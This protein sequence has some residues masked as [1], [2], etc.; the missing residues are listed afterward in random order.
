MAFYSGRYDTYFILG[1]PN[2]EPLWNWNI[3]SRVVPLLDPIISAARGRAAV[4]STQYLPD[5]RGTVKFGRIGWNARGHQKWA[6]GSPSN[7]EESSTWRFLDVEMWAPSWS[8]C[9]DRAPDVFLHIGNEALGGGYNRELA[10]NP[11]IILAVVAHLSTEMPVK[12]RLAVNELLRITDARLCGYKQRQWGTPTGMGA[13]TH[14]IQDLCLSGLFKPHPKPS[15]RHTGVV[16]GTVLS[17]EWEPIEASNSTWGAMDTRR[18]SFH[19][20]GN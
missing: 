8:R 11:V 13:F 15:Q 6:H 1:N 14:S 18:R 17:E 19:H 9:D 10:F 12:I 3:W 20:D 2:V 5:Q 7:S 16:D 4:R